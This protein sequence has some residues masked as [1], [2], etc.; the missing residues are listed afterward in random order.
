MKCERH[1]SKSSTLALAS[2]Q[3][4]TCLPDA[5][6]QDATT[7]INLRTDLCLPSSS[8]ISLIFGHRLDRVREMSIFLPAEEAGQPLNKV[9]ET[10]EV[11]IFLKDDAEDAEVTV[12]VDPVETVK[13]LLPSLNVSLLLPLPEEDILSPPPPSHSCV[14][15]KMNSEKERLAFIRQN[16]FPFLGGGARQHPLQDLSDITLEEFLRQNAE[17]R[18][19]RYADRHT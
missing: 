1:Y 9:R 10:Q 6:S 14:V 16:H 13:P 8:R 3:S 4:A 11:S 7:V 19:Q 17:A 18:K 12:T 15:K 2:L 5:I